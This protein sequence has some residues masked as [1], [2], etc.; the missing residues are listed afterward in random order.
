MEV[1]DSVIVEF[2]GR[3]GTYDASD[4]IA[5]DPQI[6]QFINLLKLPVHQTQPLGFKTFTSIDDDSANNYTSTM[7]F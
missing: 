1:V 4:P 7:Y 5:V 6:L 2:G 3:A